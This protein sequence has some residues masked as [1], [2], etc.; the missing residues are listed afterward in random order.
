MIFIYLFILDL[1]YNRDVSNIFFLNFGN[2]LPYRLKWL[3]SS[4][5]NQK[6]SFSLPKAKVSWKAS[7]LKPTYNYS[8]NQIPSH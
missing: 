2:N 5:V 6:T 1:K 4:L 8:K 3:R 7:P